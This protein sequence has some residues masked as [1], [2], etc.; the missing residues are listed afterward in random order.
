MDLKERHEAFKKVVL[1]KNFS[2]SNPI[3][4]KRR[5]QKIF[6]YRRAT[7]LVF[8]L[9]LIWGGQQFV[10]QNHFFS[11]LWPASGIA[12]SALFLRGNIMLGGLFLGSF[13]SFYYYHFDVLFS[14]ILSG[15]FMFYIYAI[16]Q[17]CLRYIGPVAPLIKQTIFWKFIAL[18]TPLSAAYALIFFK[19]L[20]LIEPSLTLLPIHIGFFWIAQ[21]IGILCLT[22]LCLSVD[23]FDYQYYFSKENKTWWGVSLL[24][25]SAHLLYYILPGGW[26]SLFLSLFFII[27]MGGYAKKFGQFPTL[28]TFFGLSIVY[29]SALRAPYAIFHTQ[30]TLA[31]TFY[32]LLLFL[33]NIL[34]SVSLSIAKKERSLFPS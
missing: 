30:S 32:L 18:L 11:P 20:K 23:P 15:L 7:E 33:I 34:F 26:P 17:L 28:V 5:Y 13:L 24:I 3:I 27:C 1:T 6:L 21:M 4:F 8:G 2:L 12:L 25:F 22:P 9:L 29:L 14:L 19:I 31:Q 10:L 16:R